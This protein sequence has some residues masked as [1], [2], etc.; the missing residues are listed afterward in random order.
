MKWLFESKHLDI[1]EVAHKSKVS[2]STIY[3]V[4]NGTIPHRQI[5]YALAC[6][7][8]LDEEEIKHVLGLGGYATERGNTLGE[9]LKWFL[10]IE[11]ITEQKLSEDAGIN[12]R[13]IARV[14]HHNVV[15]YKSTVLAL[16]AAMKLGDDEKNEMLELAGYAAEK[17]CTLGGELERLSMQKHLTKKDLSERS[18]LGLSTIYDVL[19]DAVAP[20][21]LTVLKIIDAIGLSEEEKRS[22]LE[23]GNYVEQRGTLGGELKRQA[24]EK[25]LTK[26]QLSELFGV[27]EDT[28]N[29][30][31]ANETVPKFETLFA[32]TSAMKIEGTTQRYIYKL[33]GYDLCTLGGELRLLAAQRGL[34]K[35]NLSALTGIKIR[36]IRAIF[37][38]SVMPKFE[39]ISALVSAMKLDGAAHRYIDN[40]AGRGT[41]T[42]GCELHML[43]A[44][45]GFTEDALGDSAAIGRDTVRGI[46]RDEIVPKFEDIFGLV[47]A[48][49]LEDMELRYVYK[50]AGYDLFTL[51]GELRLF[52]AERGFSED[53][54]VALSGVVHRRLNAIFHNEAAPSTWDLLK[55]ANSLELGD[56]EMSYVLKLAGIS[57]ERRSTL[58][59]ELERLAILGRLDKNMLSATAKVGRNTLDGILHNETTPSLEALT[60]IANAMNLEY[61]NRE[62]VLEL[63]GGAERSETPGG[64]LERLMYLK[65]MTQATLCKD[66]GV[67][68]TFIIEALR[69][70]K[71]IGDK[72]ARK[73]IGALHLEEEDLEYVYKLLGYDVA[74]IEKMLRKEE[75]TV[76]CVKKKSISER[77]NDMADTLNGAGIPV[78]EEARNKA[79]EYVQK[80]VNDGFIRGS[81]ASANVAAVALYAS[82]RNA[83]VV[84]VLEDITQ[85]LGLKHDAV[86]NTYEAMRSELGIAAKPL[87]TASFVEYYLSKLARRDVLDDALNLLNDHAGSMFSGKDQ[88]KI[89]ATVICTASIR[90][91]AGHIDPA[92]LM[93]ECGLVTSPNVKLETLL[94]MCNKLEKRIREGN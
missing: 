45:R 50:L 87:D 39:D 29:H 76:A 72:T 7:M 13:A 49:K 62:Y 12:R 83:D 17:R 77:L 58:G 78:T 18:G 41:C 88:R 55:I 52:A 36:K 46:L 9:R 30:I 40:L 38:N 65:G 2:R 11:G 51:G 31:F 90:S 16:A 80:C 82:C 28:M 81:R 93:K 79:A 63:V 24:M 75:E 53:A 71:A 42:L 19:N 43:A 74:R 91:D 8:D 92:D 10:E 61:E 27:H 20:L 6:A 21:Q 44:E 67:H 33:A 15:P 14:I 26:D 57:T 47:S 4:L 35:D 85:A 54:L 89:A 69:N 66:S 84:V 3:N 37:L 34:A 25:K 94:D 48:M 70:K 1:D 32:L 59:E 86:H 60:R 23:L 56:A 64:E 73:L 5:L 68:R 22:V